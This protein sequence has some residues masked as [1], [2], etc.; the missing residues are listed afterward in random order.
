MRLLRRSKLGCRPHAFGVQVRPVVL[1]RLHS[2]ALEELLSEFWVAVLESLL[3]WASAKRRHLRRLGVTQ[4]QA[5]ASSHSA[6]GDGATAKLQRT[7]LVEKVVPLESP[8]LLE[9]VARRHWRG[10]S[11]AVHGPQS[12]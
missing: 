1:E 5:S 7:R 6:A 11:R 8:L 10:G 4:R 2:I 12:P 3:R 9:R